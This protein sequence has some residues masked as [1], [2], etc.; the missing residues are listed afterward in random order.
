MDASLFA[1]FAEVEQRHWWFQARREIVLALA[2]DLLPEGTRV[3]D[4]G[5]GTGFVL[6]RLRERYDAF[7]VDVSPIAVDLCRARGLDRVAQGRTEDLS[8]LEGRRFGG[9]FLLD[10]L[11]HLDDDLGALA[12]LRE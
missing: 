2:G 3:L 1:T 6:E 9:I 7:G 10:V 4:V 8:A 12:R 11:E 5:C